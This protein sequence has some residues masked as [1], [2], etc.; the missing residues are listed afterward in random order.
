MDEPQASFGSRE[1]RIAENEAWCRRLNERKAQ[2]I[3]SG[4]PTA[5]FRCECWQMD[6][7]SRFR[8]SEEEWREA[9]S[10]PDRFVV[11]PE[12]VARDV[13]VVVKERPNF[14]LVEKNGEAGEVVEELE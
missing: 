6:C 9:R 10:R 11:A 4:L 5:G 13:E 3:A 7:G 1:E 2:W 12:H 14:W 8:L